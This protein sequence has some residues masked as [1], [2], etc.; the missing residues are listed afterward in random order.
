MADITEI[1]IVEGQDL[2]NTSEQ[3]VKVSIASLEPKEEIWTLA[4]I[5]S[6]I[7]EIDVIKNNALKSYE[8][9]I[10]SLDAKR[11]WLT[12]VKAQVETVVSEK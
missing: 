11:E 9:Q 10:V 8:V 2:E 3:D 7:K 1:K 6:S 12:S 5:E 4:M